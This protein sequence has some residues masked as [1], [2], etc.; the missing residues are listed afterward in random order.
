MKDI[1]NNQLNDESFMDNSAHSNFR[2]FLTYKKGWKPNLPAVWVNAKAYLNTEG[3]KSHITG[4]LTL[5][6]ALLADNKIGVRYGA[7]NDGI[8]FEDSVFIGL[9]EDRAIRYE[10]TC[11]VDGHGIRASM[12]ADPKRPPLVLN[13]VVFKNYKCG[14]EA[15]TFYVDNRMTDDMGNP[16]RANNMTVINSEYKNKPRLNG[17][18][19][20]AMKNWHMEDYDGS[21]GPD[22]T[23]PGFLIRDNARMKAFLPENTCEPLWYDGSGCTAF[24]E[25]ACLRLVHLMPTGRVTKGNTDIDRLELTDDNTGK[26]YKFTTNE[27]GKAI[28]VLPAGQYSGEFL[29]TNGIP[30]TIDT[31]EIKTYDEPRCSNFVT[32]QDFSFTN[33]APPSPA[34]SAAP[35]IT[36]DKSYQLSRT[37][38]KCPYG[39]T[40]RLFKNE[41]VSGIEECHDRCFNMPTCNFFT[42][43]PDKQ[44]CMGC[45]LASEDELSSTSGNYDSYE[46][47]SIK[48]PEDFGYDLWSGVDGMSP[49]KGMNK[50]C[51]WKGGDRIGKHTTSTRKGCYNLCKDTSGCTLFSWGEDHG[52][53]KDRGVCLLCKSDLNLAG[54]SGI[55]SYSMVP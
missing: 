6:K 32:D 11:P 33:T 46:L 4:N 1:N 10:K 24:C 54:H 29:D 18:S 16:V 7:W 8:A 20:N 5:K 48:T 17:C 19:S 49:G 14:T 25:G 35:T 47:T 9:S 36:F 30:V 23:G 38:A 21:V 52:A 31:V 27:Y 53:S 12:N 26:S 37:G 51:P 34:P 39:D 55:Y 15:L 13:D 28:V 50:K 22:V 43:G 40:R 44:D 42:Y 41:P 3:L 2:G 45:A